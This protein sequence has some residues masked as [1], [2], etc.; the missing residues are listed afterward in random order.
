MQKVSKGRPLPALQLARDAA[1]H[2]PRPLRRVGQLLHAAG[3]R[4]RLRRALRARRHR[5]RVVRGEHRGHN[6][7][8]LLI[9]EHIDRTASGDAPVRPRLRVVEFR[10]C[11]HNSAEGG[12]RSAL[13]LA[14]L[15]L[16]S[17]VRDTA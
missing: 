10:H 11:L 5:P 1:A 16:P 4:A 3:A 2:A 12:E 14:S 15:C 8:G 7:Q 17:C 9:G 6:K 13:T